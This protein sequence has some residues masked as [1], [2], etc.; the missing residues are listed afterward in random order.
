VKQ[1]ILFIHLHSEVIEIWFKSLVLHLC[2]VTEV[3]V[4]PN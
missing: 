4:L 1:A 3:I 2:L